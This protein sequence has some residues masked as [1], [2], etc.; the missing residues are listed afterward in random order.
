MF[1]G[2][3][4]PAAH[5]VRVVTWNREKPPGRVNRASVMV[6]PPGLLEGNRKRCSGEDINLDRD[7]EWAACLQ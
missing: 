6:W 3:R 7:V 5:L 1:R 2:T 4:D